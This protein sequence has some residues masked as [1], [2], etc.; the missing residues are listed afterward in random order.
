MA[1]LDIQQEIPFTWIHQCMYM[2]GRQFSTS[3]DVIVCGDYTN[4]VP[5]DSSLSGSRG[6]VLE[7]LR[8]MRG[9]LNSS[10]VEKAQQEF[11]DKVKVKI[12]MWLDHVSYDPASVFAEFKKNKGPEVN[13]H[14]DSNFWWNEAQKIA[15][16]LSQRKGAGTKFDLTCARNIMYNLGIYPVELQTQDTRDCLVQIMKWYFLDDADPRLFFRDDFFGK[17]VDDKCFYFDDF[18]RFAPSPTTSP[19]R[20]IEEH[21]LGVNAIDEQGSLYRDFKDDFKEFNFV[22][23]LDFVRACF[24][25]IAMSRPD[26]NLVNRV[27]TTDKRVR[28]FWV[29][30]RPRNGCTASRRKI[31]QTLHPTPCIATTLHPTS[32]TRRMVK[33]SANFRILM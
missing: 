12:D 25:C 4:D 20:M 14:W 23:V 27:N 15:S 21:V 32:T 26:D 1:D 24:Q 16:D 13:E 29:N 31:F 2:R 33:L 22:E 17:G 7:V 11:Y 18:S 9:G 19:F 3:G 6:D 30:T 8:S 5:L 10:I 28:S